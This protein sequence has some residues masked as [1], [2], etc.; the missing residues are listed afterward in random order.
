MLCASSKAHTFVKTTSL[1]QYNKQ[2]TTTDKCS[3]TILKPDDC[4]WWWTSCEIGDIA[5]ITTMEM[6]TLNVE[7]HCVYSR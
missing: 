1:N 7:Y 3:K 2:N 4:T 5:I 6:I